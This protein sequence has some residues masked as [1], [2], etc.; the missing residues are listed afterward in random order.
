[1]EENIK[2]K[3]FVFA[4]ELAFRDATMRGEYQAQQETKETNIDAYKKAKNNI[5]KKPEPQ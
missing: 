2:E 5:R 1:M 4:Y 3:I